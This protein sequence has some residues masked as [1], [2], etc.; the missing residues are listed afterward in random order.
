MSS[1]YI[2]IN[3]EGE[4]LYVIEQTTHTGHHVRPVFTKDLNVAF[5][6]TSLPRQLTAQEKEWVKIPAWADRKVYIGE[7]E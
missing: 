1:T 6:G 2:W 5:V 3:R 4:F 7:K